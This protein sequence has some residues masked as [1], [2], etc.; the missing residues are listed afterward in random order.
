MSGY[1]L[2]LAEFSIASL[3]HLMALIR[4]G[5]I[6]RYKMK[7]QKEIAPFLMALL[8]NWTLVCVLILPYEVYGIAVWRPVDGLSR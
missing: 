7:A 4:I 3:F 1:L 2:N 8:F 5:L 6:F